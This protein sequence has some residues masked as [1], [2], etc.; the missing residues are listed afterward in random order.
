MTVED[1]V[2]QTIGSLVV[3]NIALKSMVEELTS[4]NAKLK[5]EQASPRTDERP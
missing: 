3:E 1:K 4:E 5:A 2:K